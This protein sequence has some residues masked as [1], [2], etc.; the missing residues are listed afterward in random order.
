AVALRRVVVAGR[1]DPLAQLAGLVVDREE[2]RDAAAVARGLVHVGGHDQR[3]GGDDRRVLD[4]LVHLVLGDHLAGLRVDGLDVQLTLLERAAL[5]DR[6]HL[7]ATAVPGVVAAVGVLGRPQLLAGGDVP[8][9]AA[10]GAARGDRGAADG[11]V[12]EPD[13]ERAGLGRLVPQL[14]AGLQVDRGDLGAALRFG[15]GR[16]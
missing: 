15:L 8:G 1:R 13:G 5:A 12:A 3:V 4:P 7:R 10:A 11:D 9:G 14:L 2:V 16:R 6:D